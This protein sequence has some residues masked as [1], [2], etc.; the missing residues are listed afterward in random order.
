MVKEVR[1]KELILQNGDVMP[2]GLCVWCGNLFFFIQWGFHNLLANSL[3]CGHIASCWT[4][5][6]RPLPEQ[7]HTNC[8]STGVGPTDF[9]TSL[10]FAKTA[11]GRIA[12]DDCLHVLVHPHKDHGPKSPAE[13]PFKHFLLAILP[14]AKLLIY[15]TRLKADIMQ[16]ILL[17]TAMCMLRRLGRLPQ[18]PVIRRAMMD[19]SLWR[20][21]LL[22]ETAAP[23]RKTR[24]QPLRR[25]GAAQIQNNSIEL[26]LHHTSCLC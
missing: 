1:E 14:V 26:C 17:L 19:S 5:Q 21:S 2:Y 23:I 8:R 18:R 3:H 24:C 9:T 25:C 16:V 13:V 7:K 6:H 4:S 15:Q 22:W 20:T 11:R 10:P 12:V